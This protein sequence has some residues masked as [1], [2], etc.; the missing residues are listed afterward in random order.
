[1]GNLKQKTPNDIISYVFVYVGNKIK[2]IL[3]SSG[4]AMHIVPATN[5]PY[6]AKDGTTQWNLPSDASK[7]IDLVFFQ[8]PEA[9]VKKFNDIC[10]YNKCE[11]FITN[12]TQSPNP[13][14]TTDLT[15]VSA[16]SVKPT[17]INKIKVENIINSIKTQ[18]NTLL[19]KCSKDTEVT[20]VKL[21]EIIKK[22]DV[23][24]AEPIT[25][26]KALIIFF[27]SFAKIKM[28]QTEYTLFVTLIFQPFLNAIIIIYNQLN[29]IYSFLVNYFDNLSSVQKQAY[30][31]TKGQLKLLQGG[32]KKRYLKNKS[33]NNK[34]IYKRSKKNKHTRKNK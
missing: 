16:T 20:D 18:F 14:S 12:K 25:F 26:K 11:Q 1:M 2:E 15:S 30:M 32:R 22:Y 27:T 28:N 29:L 34:N 21:I 17:D 8:F 9:M 24:T 3:S 13:A 23:T 7:A 33:I 19:T 31:P 4:W 10:S 6:Y 5:Q